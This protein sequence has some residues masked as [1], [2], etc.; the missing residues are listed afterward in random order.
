MFI[1][2]SKVMNSI[3]INRTIGVIHLGGMVFQNTYGFIV[4]KNIFFDKLYIV[5]FIAI[6]FSWLVCKDECF[7][8]YISKK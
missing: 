5:S 6:P 3:T 1:I 7:V 8:S 4:D 2:A